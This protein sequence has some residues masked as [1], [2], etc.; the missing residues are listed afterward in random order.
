MSDELV[1]H[2]IYGYVC[3]AHR[4]GWPKERVWAMIDEAMVK[5]REV[6]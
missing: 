3:E 6:E 5:L 4:L 2:I 1:L